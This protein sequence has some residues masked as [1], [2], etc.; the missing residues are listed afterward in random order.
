MALHLA[1]EDRDQG[2]S[3]EVWQPALVDVWNQLGPRERV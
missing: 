2:L 1:I 3:D